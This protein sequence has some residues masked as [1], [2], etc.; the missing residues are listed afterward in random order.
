MGALSAQTGLT[1]RHE[2]AYESAGVWA[3]KRADRLIKLGKRRRGHASDGVRMEPGR[4]Q[5]SPVENATLS[6]MRIG[7]M[8]R[9]VIDSAREW[10]WRMQTK[11]VQ[12]CQRA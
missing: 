10:R 4:R 12:M 5:G 8:V 1:F 3:A 2:D 6:T 9:G 7:T 11:A